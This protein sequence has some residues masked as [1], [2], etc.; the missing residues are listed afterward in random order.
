MESYWNNGVLEGYRMATITRSILAEVESEKHDNLQMVGGGDSNELHKNTK[1][2][3][4]NHRK[5][6]N[7]IS[8]TEG[9]V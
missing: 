1:G 2:Q 3:L 4:G 5:G 6:I 9:R 7:A 8:G